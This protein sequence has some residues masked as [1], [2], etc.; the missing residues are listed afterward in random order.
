MP[1]C[2][3]F[4]CTRFSEKGK[5][6]GKGKSS[7]DRRL[8][9]LGNMGSGDHKVGCGFRSAFSALETGLYKGSTAAITVQT[10]YSCNSIGNQ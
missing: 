4:R 10:Q 9:Q 7:D 8:Q 5:G 3:P 1:C 6:K 2:N